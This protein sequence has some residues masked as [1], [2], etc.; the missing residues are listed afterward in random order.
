L[1]LLL[2][3]LDTNKYESKDTKQGLIL[4][5]KVSD[6]ILKYWE[7]RTCEFISP[8][9]AFSGNVQRLSAPHVVQMT[10][11]AAGSA[12]LWSLCYRIS[13]NTVSAQPQVPSGF[14][15]SEMLGAYII[16]TLSIIRRYSAV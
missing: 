7:Y 11:V 14:D 2:A 3:S 1:I 8:A 10:V 5:L 6:F 16:P 9:Q 12:A 13:T 4:Q 15:V